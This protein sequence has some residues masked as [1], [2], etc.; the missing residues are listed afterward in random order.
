MPAELTPSALALLLAVAWDVLLGEPPAKLHPVVWIGRAIDL[1]VRVAPRRPPALQL[2]YGAAVAVV[3]PTAF[4]LAAGALLAA[5]ADVP[6]LRLA[7]EVALLKSAFAL[8]A[9]GDAALVVRDA[10]RA[11]SRRR[12]RRAAQPVQP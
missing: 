6:L 10:L 8:R 11:R 9:L 2:L 7:L 3:L 12:T 5:V 4:A 1:A